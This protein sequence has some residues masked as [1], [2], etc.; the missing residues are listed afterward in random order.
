[1]QIRELMSR[2]VIL[3]S[4][5]QTIGEV[6]QMMV[7]RDIGFMPVGDHDRLVGMVTDRDIVVRGVAAGK[8]LDTPVSEVMTADVKYCFEDE[9]IDHVVTNMGVNQVRRLPV[10][11]RDK[12][13]VGIITLADAALEH[14]PVVVGEAL[15][16]VVEPGGEHCQ[17]VAA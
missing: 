3:A 1:M 17:S 13:L 10:M 14:D 15:L 8:G 9:D 6:A 5:R 16:R 12:R 2:D 11:N 4:P 7:A